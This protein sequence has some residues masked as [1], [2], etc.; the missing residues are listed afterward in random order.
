MILLIS[1]QRESTTFFPLTIMHPVWPCPRHISPHLQFLFDNAPAADPD[2]VI[3]VTCGG[4]HVKNVS[5]GRKNE[6]EYGQHFIFV[7]I[8]VSVSPHT[9]YSQWTTVYFKQCDVWKHWLHDPLTSSEIATLRA[10]EHEWRSQTKVVRSKQSGEHSHITCIKTTS[11]TDIPSQDHL[12][13]FIHHP[14]C[15][16]RDQTLSLGGPTPCKIL[17]PA[18]FYLFLIPGDNSAHRC[19]Y[20]YS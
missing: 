15:N 12:V 2:K 5:A 19:A 11:N 17:P 1:A 10:K 16:L 14:Q 13:H 3:N 18:R 4:P 6:T 9:W 20:I 7:C 8:Q